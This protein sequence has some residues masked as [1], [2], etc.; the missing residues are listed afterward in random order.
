MSPP[1]PGLAGHVSMVLTRPRRLRCRIDAVENL[2]LATE[3]GYQPNHPAR[4]L[5][6]FQ[7]H[8][9]GLRHPRHHQSASIPDWSGAAARRRAGGY[10]VLIT[11]PTACRRRASCPRMAAAGTPDGVVGTFFHL[12][13]PD[14]AAL[15]RHGLRGAA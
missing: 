2:K 8:D 3:L 12:R 6:H 13:V 14:L 4:N 1:P 5:R 15:S 10:D 11:I 9:A 7:D